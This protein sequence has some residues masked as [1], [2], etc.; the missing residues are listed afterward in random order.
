MMT[1]D[2]MAAESFSP[3]LT[4]HMIPEYSECDPETLK[5]GISG[6]QMPTHRYEENRDSSFIF[7]ERITR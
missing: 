3:L 7:T 4:L 5:N 6:I 2:A 1:E